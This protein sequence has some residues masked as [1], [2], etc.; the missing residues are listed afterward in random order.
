MNFTK[1]EKL[2]Q[3]EKYRQEIKEYT[4]KKSSL[5]KPY[6]F[7]NKHGQDAFLKENGLRRA[8]IRVLEKEKVI[9]K[10][11]SWGWNRGYYTIITPEFLAERNK[12]ERE[13]K[14]NEVAFKTLKEMG[15]PVINELL[16]HNKAYP[17]LQW[18]FENCEKKGK[19][20]D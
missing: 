1:E 5:W 10:K 4:V 14:V 18:I 15:V 19:R 6:F 13:W 12:T 3:I 16:W 11:A 9:E 2:E 20:N 7:K 17:L 8:A